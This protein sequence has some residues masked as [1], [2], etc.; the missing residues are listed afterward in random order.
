MEK[1]YRYIW[2]FIAV[3]FGIVVLGFFKT[4]FNK[5]PRFE[6]TS[7][8]IHFHAAS[9]LIWFGLLFVQPILINRRKFKLHRNI[10]KVSYF[11][12]PIITLSTI[13]VCKGLYIRTLTQY[14][15]NICIGNLIFPFAQIAV[16]DSLYILAILNVRKTAYHMRY[17]IASSIILL[18][19][20][21]R[22]VL[23]YWVG[24]PSQQSASLTFLFSAALFL[25][26]FIYD[27]RSGKIY[28]PYIVSLIFLTLFVVSYTWFPQTALWQNVC[29]KF[30]QIAF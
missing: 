1:S 7:F 17:M 12:V 28:S 19:P 27:W 5:F 21:M 2:I 24:I 23:F 13:F 16:F 4:Y 15:K 22:R 14:P 18:G 11:L 8:A 30:V 26:L 9:F 20:A 29:G 10:G 6:N 25:V 3:I